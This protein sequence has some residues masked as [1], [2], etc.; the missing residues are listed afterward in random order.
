MLF[1]AGAKN[2]NEYLQHNKIS[3]HVRKFWVE[4]NE[5][6]ALTAYWQVNRQLY[7]KKCKYIRSTEKGIKIY[8]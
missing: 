2:L 3:E 6:K 4:L 8:T 5:V 7:H 1:K